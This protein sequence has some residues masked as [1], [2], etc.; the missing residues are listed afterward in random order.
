MGSRPKVL[1]RSLNEAGEVDSSIS[2]G[3]QIKHDAWSESVCVRGG[4]GGGGAKG[5]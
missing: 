5:I 1:L 4:G 3:S 2:G